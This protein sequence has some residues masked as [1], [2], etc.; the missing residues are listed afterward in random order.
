MDIQEL[1]K[2]LNCDDAFLASLIQKFIEEVSAITK[3]IDKAATEGKWDIVRSNAH[4][5]LS[6]VRI[7]D[8]KELIKTLE[9]LEIEAGD[10]NNIPKLKT[11]VNNL[12]ALVNTSITEMHKTLEEINS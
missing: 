11:E 5:M 4:K 3:T 2:Y 10:A 7:F 12:S 9:T 6:S 8:I 1:K